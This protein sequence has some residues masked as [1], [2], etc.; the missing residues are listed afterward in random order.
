MIMYAKLN[1]FKLSSLISRTPI[2]S[3]LGRWLA[4]RSTELLKDRLS[5]L[6]EPSIKIVLLSSSRVR[7]ESSV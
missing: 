2:Q 1:L 5:H 6:N 4:L 3:L 7:R